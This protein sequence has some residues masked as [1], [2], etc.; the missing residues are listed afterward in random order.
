MKKVFGNIESLAH[1]FYYKT[2]DEE[3][4]TRSAWF[5][6]NRFGSYGTCIGYIFKGKDGQKTLLASDS[7]M[8]A[9]TAKHLN[10]LTN[11]CPFSYIRVPFH[12]GDSF[13]CYRTQ[14]DVLKRIAELF[15]NRLESEMSAKRTYT[16]KPDRE[17]ALELLKNM[18]DFVR[19]TGARIK[20]LA[21]YNK[22]LSVALSA[23][24]IKKASARVR[25]QAKKQ[26]EKTKKLV[27]KFKRDV[28]KKPMLDL[29]KEYAFDF[30][31]Y[32]KSQAEL[33]AHDLFMQMFDVDFYNPSF[34][35][36]DKENDVVK[37]TQNI[38]MPI[39][40]VL[41]L[42]KMWKHKHNIVGLELGQYMVIA[43]NNKYV[44]IG[45]HTI[46]IQ[47]VQA[48]ADVLL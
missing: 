6:G 36:V 22:Y 10:A 41:P 26:A 46:P 30:R 33:K 48:L 44:K 25:E 39:K 37:T 11:A 31:H 34:V 1:E 3:C 12:Y 27:E 5:K 20:G 47:N 18:N 9:T 17:Y 4:R 29:I 45:C 43:N 23:E 32:G 14:K 16:R 7:Y 2:H 24:N 15:V 28:A 35:I 42:L 13:Y 8:S 40:D 38:T 21:K 19:I